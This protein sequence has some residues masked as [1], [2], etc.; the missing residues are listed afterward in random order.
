MSV[1][2]CFIGRF[3]ALFRYFVLKLEQKNTCILNCFPIFRT[4]FSHIIFEMNANFM[5]L[6]APFRILSFLFQ[7]A[8]AE[9]GKYTSADVSIVG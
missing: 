4:L 7:A 9:I 6:C 5:F 8:S 1:L 2:V 3:S